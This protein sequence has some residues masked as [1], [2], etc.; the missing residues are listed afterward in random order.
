MAHNIRRFTIFSLYTFLGITNS[1][2]L[3]RNL[4]LEICKKRDVKKLIY[5]LLLISNKKFVVN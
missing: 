5:S 2:P 3:N 1:I 4:V